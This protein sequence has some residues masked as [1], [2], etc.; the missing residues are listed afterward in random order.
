MTPEQ[1]AAM[2][3]HRDE[4][5][6]W[7][8]CTDPANKP[9]A[10]RVVM[11]FYAKI[12]KPTPRFWWCQSPW[13][14]QMVMNIAKNAKALPDNLRANLGDNLRA[15]LRD[16]LGDNLW[17]N[18][19]ANL[20]DNLGDNL[21]D[22]KL[23]Y[24][25][26]ELWGQME[27]YWISYYSFAPTIGIKFT[28]DQQA[29]LNNWE[30]LGHS[31]GFWFPFE[32]ICFMCDRPEKIGL[33][34]QG[35]MHDDKEHSVRYRD[36]W[37]VSAVHGQRVPDWIISNPEL[38]TAEKIKQEENAEVRRVMIDLFGSLKY[39][40]ETKAKMVHADVWHGLPRGLF[41]DCHGDRY[42]YGSDNSTG[43]IY[44]MPVAAEC[45]TCTQAHENIC[46]FSE[47]LITQ[48]S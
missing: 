1:T 15:N 12:G 25:P 7:G 17:A 29:L 42:L 19:R 16:N 4:A 18:L 26:M 43:R 48:Q 8:R 27:L 37:G 33:D 46:G 30:S 21:G 40:H 13:Q 41:E 24:F 44:S 28:P 32:G 38:I 6:A 10:E 2:Y 45:Q 35:R 31:S 47:D 23:E 11:E 22:N 5:L 14:A 34:A 36:G 39:L 20:R 3:R 9:E